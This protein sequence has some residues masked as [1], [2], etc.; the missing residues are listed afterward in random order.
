MLR[1]ALDV[2]WED[3]NYYA[4]LPALRCPIPR[5]SVKIRE[6]RVR[7]ASHCVRHLDQGTK[8]EAC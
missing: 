3:H 4:Q 6:R 8:D 1:M 5:V 7:L 2:N